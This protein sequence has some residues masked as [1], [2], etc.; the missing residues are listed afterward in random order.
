NLE[1]PQIRWASKGGPVAGGVDTSD[2]ALDIVA[3]RS[4][5]GNTWQWK[6]E[7]EFAERTGHRWYWDSAGARAIRAEGER[8][9]AQIEAARFPFDGSFCDFRPDPAWPV[10]VDEGGYDRPRAYSTSFMPS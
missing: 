7:D 8:V 1:E 9:A 3:Y 6:D 4:E 10:H 2:N 5:G